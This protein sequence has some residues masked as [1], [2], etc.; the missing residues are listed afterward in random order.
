MNDDFV[1]EQD[2]AGNLSVGEWLR[3]QRLAKQ[4]SIA[5]VAGHLCLREDRIMAI[6][7]NDH[8]EDISAYIKG[9]IRGYAALL[10]IDSAI[11]EDKLA[12]LTIDKRPYASPMK[13]KLAQQYPL[14]NFWQGR[15]PSIKLIAGV[16]FILWVIARA[17]VHNYDVDETTQRLEDLV[18]VE[19]PVILTQQNN[20]DN[21]DSNAEEE[22]S[23]K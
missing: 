22:S 6:E 2:E 11:V 18:R 16:M 17:W 10:G 21:T 7:E 8:K 14:R 9:Y 12:H 4:L 23:T 20:A 13:P 1:E 15:R 19:A 5:D 3:E